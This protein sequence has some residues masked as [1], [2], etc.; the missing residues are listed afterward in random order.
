[1]KGTALVLTAL[2]LALAACGGGSDRLSRDELA[3]RASKICTDQAA[4]IAQ[5]PRGPNNPINAAG[6][7]GAILSVYETGIK[8]F[9]ALEPPK[10]EEATYQAYLRELDR[11]ADILRTL[12]AAAAVQQLKAY[13][14]GQAALHRSRVRLAALQRRLGFTGCAGPASK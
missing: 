2:A 13:V 1:V 8:R 11:N 7:I 9:H 12:R 5:I 6:Y 10:D 3:S 4:T 14:T